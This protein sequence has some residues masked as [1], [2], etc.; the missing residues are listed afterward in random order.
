MTGRWTY[1]TSA[2]GVLLLAAAAFTCPMTPC[3]SWPW[4][5]GSGQP[6]PGCGRW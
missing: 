6:W 5:A 4:T 3:I 1:R 2:T